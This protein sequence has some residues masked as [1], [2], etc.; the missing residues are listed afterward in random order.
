M[1]ESDTKHLFDNRFG[2]GQSTVDG[3][4]RRRT[5]CS[6]ERHSW[7]RGTA[8]ADAAWRAGARGLG[9]HVVVTEVDP[10]RALEAV[11]EGF[12]VM[13]MAEAATI[14]DFF[15]T[16]TGDCHVIDGAVLETMKDGAILANS[17][18]FDNEIDLEALEGMS[19]GKRRVRDHV[20]EYRM[21][22]GRTL[23]LLGEGRLVNL[24]AAEGHPASVNGHVLREPRRW[25]RSGSWRTNRRWTT[26]C[27]SCRIRSTRRLRG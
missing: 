5:C 7:W 22:D 26:R 14:G 6:R 17:G 8:G 15:V 4:V 13:P 18:H 1:N 2:T 9:A 24:A 16:V 25:E 27:T 23:F 20:D 11:M 12:T 3:I 10:V 19:E 21:G